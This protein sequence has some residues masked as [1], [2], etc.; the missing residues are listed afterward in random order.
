MRV[1]SLHRSSFRRAWL[2]AAF[3]ALMLLGCGGGGSGDGGG[4][5]TVAIL[6]SFGQ[7]VD[8]GNGGVG[9]GDSGADGTAGEGKPIVGARVEVTDAIGK[10]V[11][12]TTDAQGYYRVKVTSFTP[13]FVAKITKSD[14]KVLYSLSVAALKVNGFI[15]LNLSGLTD[16]VASD[17]AVAAGKKGAADLTP[18]IVAANPSAIT[19]AVSNLADQLSS[20]IVAAGLNPSTFDPIGAPFRPN[21]TGYDFVLEN[22]KVVVAADGSTQVT[23]TFAGAS[24]V[25]KYVGTWSQCFNEATGSARDTFTLSKTG[26]FTASAPGTD[27]IY[28]SPNCSGTATTKATSGT[29]VTFQ[30]TKTLG[31]ET[32]DKVDLIQ[33]GVFVKS[34]VVIKNGQ[35]Y[36]GR[37]FRDGG[38]V[39]SEGYPTSLEPIPYTRQ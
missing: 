8:A 22:V 24:P 16:K 15:T 4:G 12:G 35:L 25:D 36:V 34:V 6:D 33:Q 37:T 9:S 31:T 23:Q 10:T 29:T 32:V 7:A 11:S 26:T 27:T 20:V 13:P 3:A 39:D 5:A 18:Q 14:G 30:G 28:A 38:S 19:K 21:L 17:V 1:S 2:T